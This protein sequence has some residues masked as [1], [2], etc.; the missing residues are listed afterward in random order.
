MRTSFGLPE[1]QQRGQSSNESG[2]FTEATVILP[3]VVLN[4]LK[5]YKFRER[6]YT[7]GCKKEEALSK[8]QTP[9]PRYD[10]DG[11]PRTEER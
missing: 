2:E 7:R 1:P 5:T 11:I 6:L 8:E 9:Y 10:E 4:C 3:P